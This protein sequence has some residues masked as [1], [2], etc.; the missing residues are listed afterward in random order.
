VHRRAASSSDT[1]RGSGA[2]SRAGDTGVAQ[3]LDDRA[4]QPGGVTDLQRRAQRLDVAL[5]SEHAEKRVE[6]FGVRL[7]HRG[8]LKQHRP[9]RR[10]QV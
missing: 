5:S 9:Q 2:R 8:Q 6:T 3:A 7:E 10:L 4:G 1:T